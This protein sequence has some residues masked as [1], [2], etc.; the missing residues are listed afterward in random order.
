MGLSPGTQHNELLLHHS[1]PIINGCP[2]C[3]NP[4]EAYP[5]GCE[6]GPVLIAGPGMRPMA[7]HYGAE[8]VLPDF[9]PRC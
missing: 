6:L 4:A 3:F 7:A 1:R 2:T 5:F 9:R 8:V